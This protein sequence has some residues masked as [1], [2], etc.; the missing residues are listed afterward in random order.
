[1]DRR[2]CLA[3]APSSIVLLACTSPTQPRPNPATISLDDSSSAPG[4]AGD[5]V[6]AVGLRIDYLGQ[7]ETEISKPLLLRV[8]STGRIPAYVLALYSIGTPATRL[9]V[10]KGVSW[11][12]VSLQGTCGDGV[13][14]FPLA[15]G[16]S[17]EFRVPLS[18]HQNPELAP[19]RVSLTYRDRGGALDSVETW[20]VA[21]TPEFS[22]RH[23]LSEEE[24]VDAAQRQDLNR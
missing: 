13:G 11:H 4:V 2:Q 12:D 20:L 8:T 3:L 10:S 1:V 23:I 22:P 15:P 5:D 7:V 21:S 18:R 16:T 24:L 9:E 17:A 19:M 14:W 6:H